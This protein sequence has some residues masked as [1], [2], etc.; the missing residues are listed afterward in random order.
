AYPAAALLAADSIARAWEGSLDDRLRVHVSRLACATAIVAALVP[1]VIAGN[2]MRAHLG[3]GGCTAVA[4]GFALAGSVAAAWLRRGPSAP[5][6]PRAGAAF[7]LVAFKPYD[8][9]GNADAYNA[10][11][12]PRPGAERIRSHV[13]AGEELRLAGLPPHPAAYYLNALPVEPILS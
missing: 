8:D 11:R 6:A 3:L 12:S 2:A 1:L 5:P 4:L 9:F 10:A 7:A 13:P